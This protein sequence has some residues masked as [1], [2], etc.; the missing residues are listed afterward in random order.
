MRIGQSLVVLAALAFPFAAMADTIDVHSTGSTPAGTSD[1]NYTITSAS[2]TGPA[3]SSTPDPY[4]YQPTG[5]TNWDN[6]TGQGDSTEPTGDYTY[7]TTFNIA[8]GDNPATAIL[9]LIIAA[10]DSVDIYLNGTLVGSGGTYNQTTPFTITS[11]F[12]SGSNTLTFVDSNSGG[13]PTGIYVDASGTVSG[14]PVPE[15]SSIALLGTGLFTAA[16]FTRHKFAR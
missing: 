1:P 2:Y 5:A 7:T 15:P 13:G 3:I 11:G 14:S 9:N 8:A 4:W 6:P 12:N 16:A 10:D